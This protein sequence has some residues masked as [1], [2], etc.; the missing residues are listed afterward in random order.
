MVLPP[1]PRR[2]PLSATALQREREY[3][4]WL[5]DLPDPIR[6]DENRDESWSR[7]MRERRA[8]REKTRLQHVEQQRTKERR[9]DARLRDAR[10]EEQY[11]SA[12]HARLPWAIREQ[13]RRED[14]SVRVEFLEGRELLAF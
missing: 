4:Q 13:M 5:L 14:H 2:R 7:F 10:F 6:E 1:Q 11:Q 8:A 3:T 9:S 12:L